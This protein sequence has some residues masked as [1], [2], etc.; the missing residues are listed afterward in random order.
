MECLLRDQILVCWWFSICMGWWLC[1]AA[2]MA[3]GGLF[4]I[5]IYPGHVIFKIDQVLHLQPIILIV[6]DPDWDSRLTSRPTSPCV[7][8]P[9]TQGYYC[10]CS[11]SN[12]SW[13]N[14]HIYI[15]LMCIFGWQFTCKRACCCCL[16]LMMAP[17]RSCYQFLIMLDLIISQLNTKITEAYLWQHVTIRDLL[18]LKSRKRGVGF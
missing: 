9:H 3:A 18:G 6:M 4:T 2:D 15:I 17:F 10:T 11:S 16:I 1:V 7:C 8:P 13:H 5:M 12:V 14:G